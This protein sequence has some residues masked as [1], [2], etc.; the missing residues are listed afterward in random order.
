MTTEAVL[1]LGLFAFLLLGAFVGENGPK[2]IF[3]R[4]GP[5]L[6]ARLEGELTTGKNFLGPD[7]RENRWLTPPVA[8]PRTG[9]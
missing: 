4:S 5:R 9:F 8:S 7:G 1:L 6:A 3:A 2:Q